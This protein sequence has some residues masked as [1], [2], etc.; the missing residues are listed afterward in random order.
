MQAG[1]ALEGAENGLDIAVLLRAYTWPV[2]ELMDALRVLRSALAPSQIRVLVSGR[3]DVVLA[4]EA[5]GVHLAAHAMV[6]SDAKS[7]LAGHHPCLL[8][9]SCHDAY[10]VRR[11]AM[12]DYLTISPYGDVPA[13]GPALG[14]TGLARLVDA[15]RCPVLA[16]GGVSLADTPDLVRI[17]VH[18][19]AVRRALD[20]SSDPRRLASQFLR[21]WRE[22]LSR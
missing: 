12:A 1:L 9:A 18:G 20:E 3:M 15:A 14:A 17:G 8:G 4:G 10:E 22:H 7:V 19:V 2:R 11:A 6:P 5:D 21:S 13:K 16:L